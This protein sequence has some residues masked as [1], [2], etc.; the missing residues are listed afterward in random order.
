M[1]RVRHGVPKEQLNNLLA[2]SEEESGLRKSERKDKTTLRKQ[3]IPVGQRL[4]KSPSESD[5]TS[6]SALSSTQLLLFAISRKISPLVWFS[7]AFLFLCANF[8]TCWTKGPYLF[9][10]DISVQQ[11]AGRES[12]IALVA[13][14]TELESRMLA[15][16]RRRSRLSCSA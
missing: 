13:A 16:A 2:F 3:K 10:V 14:V 4:N 15:P 1:R 5:F 12:T 7:S 11:R 9:D 6:S 8:A